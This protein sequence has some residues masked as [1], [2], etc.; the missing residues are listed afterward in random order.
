MWPSHKQCMWMLAAL[1][2]GGLWSLLALFALNFAVIIS[3]AVGATHTVGFVAAFTRF[4]DRY[5][6]LIVG[7]VVSILVTYVPAGLLLFVACKVSLMSERTSLLCTNG[8]LDT[9]YIVLATG[10]AI[11]GAITFLVAWLAGKREA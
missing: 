1:A 3:A 8:H 7:L 4:L 9:G 2:L 11:V 10:W 5:L 6:L